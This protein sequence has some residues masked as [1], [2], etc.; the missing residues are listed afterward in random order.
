MREKIGER[1]G[2][3][4]KKKVLLIK[5]NINN[6]I[7]GGRKWSVKYAKEGERGEEK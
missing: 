3:N 4:E 5:E 2:E 1:K 7:K 6:P